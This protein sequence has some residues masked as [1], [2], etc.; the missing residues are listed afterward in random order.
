[1]DLLKRSL[2]KRL[3]AVLK[4][5]KSVL[6]LGP[7]QT[8]K[9]TLVGDCSADLYIT[10][11]I[12]K[13]RR[14]YESDP[15]RLIREVEALHR[16]NGK[17][18]IVVVDEVQKVPALMDAV[19]FLIDGG[20]GQFI[21]T[22]SS[23]RKLRHGRNVNLLPGRVIQ[24]R[25]DPLTLAELD[26]PLPDVEDF[27]LYGSLPAIH[28]EADPMI[29]EQ[30]LE[31]YVDLYLE[32][33]VRA[34]ALVR[35]IGSFENFLRLAAIESGNI[36]NFDKI[37]Q[38]VGVARTTISSYYQILEDCLIA[39]RVDPYT[40]SRSRKKLTKAP[41][42]L[43][44]DLGL[45]RLAAEEA[46][47]LPQTYLGSL[48]E[49]FIGLELIRWSR[50]QP[51]KIHVH[52]WRDPAGPEVDWLLKCNDRLLPIEVKWTDSPSYRDAKHLELFLREQPTAEKGLVV[53]RTPRPQVLADQI[54][55]VAW[56]DLPKQL[57]AWLHQP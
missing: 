42:Y 17:P 28:L 7:R 13:V 11:L 14:Q 20:K 19:Q 15:D 9:T 22:G 18:P 55:A 36:I 8:G 51:E 48:F 56:S 49:Q 3:A 43:L 50:L 57:D 35:D 6:L 32:D 52:F 10:L 5:G 1:V 31:S 46:P 47:T 16:A 29:R 37:S 38:D 54:E 24:L 2:Q 33:E 27:L 34:E 41:K 45:R 12:A 39:E 53:C 30:E 44:F 26:R 23:A 21:L 25:L 4:R 40:E